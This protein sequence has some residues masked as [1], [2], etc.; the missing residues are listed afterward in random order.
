VRHRSSCMPPMFINVG[1][2]VD[3][4][5]DALDALVGI[6]RADRKGVQM[7]AAAADRRRLDPSRPPGFDIEDDVWSA[8]I[9]VYEGH[10]GERPRGLG[11]GKDS[12]SN[13]PLM[14]WC[15][16]RNYR[17]SAEPSCGSAESGGGRPRL[18][19]CDEGQGQKPASGTS[20]SHDGDR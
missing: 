20:R 1:A 7:S 16:G 18:S 8:A 13:T 3:E 4:D 11:S 9:G 12:D 15:A 19:R 5:R 14:I 2:Y 10:G 6:V 17:A